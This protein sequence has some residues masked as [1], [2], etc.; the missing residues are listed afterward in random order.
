[1]VPP[2]VVA[3]ETAIPLPAV[4]EVTVP[5]E[6]VEEMVIAPVF[7]VR[8][9]PEPAMRLVTPVLVRVTLPVGEETPIPVPPTMLA[10]APPP[11]PPEELRV[12]VA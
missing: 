3:G 2:L 12:E 1:M 11:P 5:P 6:P 7:A 4:M 9:I 8:E 10:T